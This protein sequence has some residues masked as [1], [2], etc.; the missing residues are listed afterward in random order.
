[1][2]RTARAAGVAALAAAFVLAAVLGGRPLSHDD[3]FWHLRS[4]E[5]ILGS[6]VVPTTDP[7]SYTLPG[8]PWVTHEWGFSLLLAAVA[9][10]AGL[11]SLVP[12]RSLLVVAFFAVVA[13]AAW[14]RTWEG[15]G[16]PMSPAALPLLALFVAVAT[17]AVSRE[18]ILRAAL[19]GA[20]CFALLVL[21][22][23][24][25]RRRP[26]LGRGGAIL[27]LLLLW[28][29]LHSGVI[30]GL[31]LLAVAAAEA[32]VMAGRGSPGG[33]RLA[34]A[35]PHL[36]LLAAASIVVLINPNGLEAPLYPF[37]L[38]LLLGD[39]ASPFELGHFRGGWRG[40]QALLGLLVA[41]FALGLLRAVRR[42]RPLPT[43][44]EIAA[45]AVFAILSWASARLALEL[46]ALAV[47]LA[48]A[49]WTP[50]PAEVAIAGT[51]GSAPALRAPAGRGWL[52]TTSSVAVT[53]LCLAVAALAWA[54][55]P[56]GP[57]SAA[58]PAVATDFL[59]SNGLAGRRLFHHQNWGG[60]LGWR[61]DAPVFW[62]GR[63][64]VFAPLARE[65]T[66]T[67]FPLVA[68]RYGVEVLVLSP[69]ELQD[70]APLLGPDGEWLFAHR[71][72]AAFVFVRRDVARR[73]GGGA[74]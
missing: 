48:F 41:A 24:A 60:Y 10:V 3:I 44:G 56:P 13:A 7:F 65:V 40:A 5:L 59:E 12:L 73:V 37:R 51:E 69:R 31:F 23:P 67:P 46:V 66:T 38:A 61:L 58:F 22:L 71:S 11:A 72:G 39:S 50:R 63:N 43:P 34:A 2:S 21:A 49:L 18:L 53:L 8:A 32:V 54:A 16:R 64:D 45:L 55:R 30:F 70:L 33:R 52:P 1:M 35:A 4:G 62:D 42:R 68:R 15:L 14:R 26:T 6:G 47:P 74:E 9:R 25:F 27:A 20:L 19:V 28:A 57:I 29:N 36:A 17:W